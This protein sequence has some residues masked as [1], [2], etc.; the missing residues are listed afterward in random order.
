MEQTKRTL[1][2]ICA[3]MRGSLC[4]FLDGAVMHFLKTYLQ[5]LSRRESS[6]LKNGCITRDIGKTVRI[7]FAITQAY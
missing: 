1:Y 5:G 2:T 4:T 7:S 3:R 6:K